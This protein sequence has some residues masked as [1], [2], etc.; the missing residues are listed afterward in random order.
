MNMMTLNAESLG[1]T[2][3]EPVEEMWVL[4]AKNDIAGL[5]PESIS[6]LFGVTKDE[7]VEIQTL[8][9]YRDIRLI[10]GAEHAKGLVETDFSWDALESI[11]LKNLMTRAPM[12]RDIETNLRIAAIANKAQR[13]LAP[14][15]NKVLD[16]S[17]GAARVPLQLTTRIV[18]RLNSQTGEQTIEETKQISISDGS[19]RNPTFEDIDKLLGVST[20]PRVASQM[21]VHTHEP[22]FT[23]EDIQFARK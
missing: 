3:G 6:E 16:P 15:Q 19:A 2:V 18:K 11:A 5:P 9:V 1:K 12:E 4:I 21:A 7:I 8:P 13:R 23:I 20:K 17:Q 22:D 10:L 14:Q